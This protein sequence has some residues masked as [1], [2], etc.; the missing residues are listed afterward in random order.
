MAS[1]TFINKNAKQFES[2][3]KISEDFDPLL[4]EVFLDSDDNGVVLKVDVDAALGGEMLYVANVSTKKSC[5]AYG[6]VRF[7]RHNDY[8]KIIDNSFKKPTDSKPVYR[9]L[10]DNINITP[11]KKWRVGVT[12]IKTPAKVSIANGINSDFDERTSMKLIQIA[13]ELAGIAVDET[14]L[15]QM[16]NAEEQ[17]LG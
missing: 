1:L 5:G 2:S 16:A 11:Q 17:K 7:C 15:Y 3:D 8:Y 4:Q 12:A 10:Q 9:Y 13:L 14:E 6:Y